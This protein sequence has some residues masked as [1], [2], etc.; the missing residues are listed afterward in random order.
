MLPDDRQVMYDRCEPSPERAEVLEIT[1]GQ[2][3]HGGL[4]K[5]SIFHVYCLLRPV[6]NGKADC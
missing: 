4:S 2:F 6:R 5:L 1:G 3:A